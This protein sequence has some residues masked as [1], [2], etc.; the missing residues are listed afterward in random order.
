MESKD[1][2]PVVSNEDRKKEETHI[3]Y[4]MVFNCLTYYVFIQF[5]NLMEIG[6]SP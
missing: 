6:F 2:K 1:K 4:F 5:L 3:I